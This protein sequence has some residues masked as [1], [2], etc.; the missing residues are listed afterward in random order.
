[1]RVPPKVLIEI[2]HLKA[3]INLAENVKALMVD[4][5]REVHDA[6]FVADMVIQGAETPEG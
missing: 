6:L 1:M 5:P 2:E 3:L 4:L